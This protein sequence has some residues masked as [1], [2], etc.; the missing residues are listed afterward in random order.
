MNKLLNKQRK[1]LVIVLMIQAIMIGSL[2]SLYYYLPDFEYYFTILIAMSS[3]FTIFDFLS[4]MVF[5]FIAFRKK[6][7][8]EMKSA[9]I[10]GSDISEAYM[11]GQIGLAVCDKDSNIL[12]VNEFLASRFNN[13]V[14]KCILD[15]FP[16]LYPLT[17][18][19]ANKE[20]VKITTENHTYQVVY[21]KEAKLYV[22]KDNTDFENIY[23]DNQNQS[24]VIGYL[25]ID[26]YS[27]IQ[28]A[29]GDETKFADQLSDLRKMIMEFAESSNSLMRRIK[30]DRYLFI[31]TMQCYEKILKDK[32]S[33][34]DNVR[35][36]FPEGFTISIGVAYGFPDYSKLAKMA[37]DALDVALSRGGD[38]TVIQ[39]FGKQMNYIGGKTE[40]Q[41]SRNRVKTRTLSNSFVTTIKDFKNA[42][43]I[44][45][46]NADFDAIGS[47]LGVYLICKHF[48]IPAK[49]CW[50]EQHIESKARNA[51][52]SLYT[53]AEMNDM[54]VSMKEVSSL[55]S[56]ETLLIYC[57][58]NNPM[59][60][61]FPDLY[62]KC[63]NIAVIDH[64]RP[65]TATGKN[66]ENPLFNGIDP[67]A[68]S[69]SELVTFY[70][71]YNPNEIPIDERT[72]TLLLS[73]ICLDT[74]FFKEHATLN[75]FEASAQLKNFGAD[76]DQV[77]DFLKEELEEYRQKIFILNNSEIPYYGCLVA[78]SPDSDIISDVTLSVVAN[79]ALT[80]RGIS[81]SFA[82]GRVDEHSVK[83]SARSDGSISALLLI[84][85]LGG[86]GHLAMAACKLEN[87]H[88]DEAKAKLMNVLKEYLNDAKVNQN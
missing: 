35:K 50:E 43:I 72:A 24:P 37:S 16:G 13:I 33:I 64:H 63:H 85:K 41:S 7:K 5:N 57:D 67:S 18:D 9:E 30:D 21:L 75:S 20:S 71:T 26:N 60:S 88:V 40:L 23:I 45:H 15:V 22:F 87:T 25:A 8:A 80:I 68:S 81:L 56:D 49:I 73:G 70:I 53:K 36:K 34:V 66:I 59:I 82:I 55:I 65:L 52:E 69:A 17:D 11:F 47:C 2:I 39:P 54:F 42:I 28:I 83:I 12:W 10:I 6:G 4:A 77:T 44:P 19:T 29:I 58:H 84:E 76:S 79:E 74:H 46:D 51:V 78:T 3:F 38:Q 62:N 1:W 86:G 32:F 61:I 31:M 14:D 27:D 48:S